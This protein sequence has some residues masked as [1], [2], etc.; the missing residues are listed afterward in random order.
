[1]RTCRRDGESGSEDDDDDD[2]DGGGSTL[3]CESSIPGTTA[4]GSIG[5][6]LAGTA[7]SA[8]TATAAASPEPA[9]PAAAPLMAKDSRSG[10]GAPSTSNP[11]I[12]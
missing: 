4:S 1:M 10:G 5:D 2:D 9:A 6:A 8:G 3:L 7:G 11:A 12:D